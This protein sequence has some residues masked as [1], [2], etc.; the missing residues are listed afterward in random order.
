MPAQYQQ[1]PCPID[2]GIIKEEWLH[3]Y[4]GQTFPRH[5][6][7]HVFISWDTANK[8]GN[9]NAYSAAVVMVRTYDRKLHLV[10]VIR[11]HWTMPE[12]V[13][14]VAETYNAYRYSFNP[15]C[16]VE[17]LVEDAASGTALIQYLQSQPDQW[18]REFYV[19]PIKPQGDKQSRMIG[20]STYIENGTVLFPDF[21]TDWWAEFK[22]E[23]L[24]FPGSKYKDQVD[25]LTQCI[26]YAMQQ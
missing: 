12:L 26:N 10:N 2:G 3:Y 20:A 7:E 9:D 18:G 13:K 19:T 24:G 21:P 23:L 8:T 15:G 6:V 16:A 4:S 11:E 14:Q 1:E 17:I 25:A 5:I 22:K